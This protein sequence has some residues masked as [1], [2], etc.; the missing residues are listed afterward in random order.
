MGAAAETGLTAT[1]LEAVEVE[2]K[3]AGLAIRQAR[4]QA[5]I[6]SKHSRRL[7]ADLDYQSIATLSK[8][9]REKLAKVLRHA[10]RQRCTLR[11]WLV[12]FVRGP[13]LLTNSVGTSGKYIML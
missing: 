1:E 8:E 12:L 4:T 3:Y 13:S 2:T 6:Q 10:C 7:P 9:S 11:C 5:N